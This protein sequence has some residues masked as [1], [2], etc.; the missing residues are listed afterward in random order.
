MH[1]LMVRIYIN[2]VSSTSLNKEN[3]IQ[4]LLKMKTTY[5][6]THTHNMKGVNQWEGSHIYHQ[7]DNYKNDPNRMVFLHHKQIYN[8]TMSSSNNFHTFDRTWHIVPLDT[9]PSPSILYKF[10]Q[11]NLFSWEQISF[12][13]YILT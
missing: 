5:T 4:N 1:I 7:F 11:T 8:I 2:K 12:H 9:T 6:V 3:D 10:L 13:T